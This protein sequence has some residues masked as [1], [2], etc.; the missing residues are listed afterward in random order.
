MVP[1]K[2]TSFADDE[3]V[4]SSVVEDSQEF[5]ADLTAALNR[6][7]I[8]HPQDETLA[9]HGTS[10]EEQVARELGTFS[11]REDETENKAFMKSG[12]KKTKA[13]TNQPCTF[14]PNSF[15]I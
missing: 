7:P 11:D 12:I 4:D 9:V 8:F 6:Q 10:H 3:T 14:S 5:D 2:K 13:V 15:N 1:A